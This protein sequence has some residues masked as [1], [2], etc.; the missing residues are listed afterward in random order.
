MDQFYA[1]TWSLFTLRLTDGI[2]KAVC[3]TKKQTLIVCGKDQKPFIQDN[4]FLECDVPAPV[5]LTWG[6]HTATNE[7]K[8]VENVIITHL[9][10][11]PDYH[12]YAELRAYLGL[13]PEEDFEENSLKD[14]WRGDVWDSL[15]QA[16][17]RGT[18]LLY[19]SPSP[20]DS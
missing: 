15:Y 20:R 7:F 10:N 18:C 6:R 19:T 5:Y 16:S 2:A 3:S 12:Y 4:L 14:F 9:Y 17:L 1:A 8:D 11:K 13:S